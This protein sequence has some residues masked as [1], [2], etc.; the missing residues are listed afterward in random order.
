LT[1]IR[2]HHLLTALPPY[3]DPI[4]PLTERPKALFFD[5]F[6]TCVDWRTTVTQALYTQ[7]HAAL[8]DAT[9]SLATAVRLRATDMT[10][11]HWGIFAQAWRDS[12]KH[13]VQSLAEDPTIPFKTVD[14]H[15]LESLKELL[16]EWKI[17]GL[18]TDEQ[19]EDLSLVWHRLAPWADSAPGIRALN[20]LAQTATLS[21]GNMSLLTDLSAQGQM[22]F[23]HVFSGELFGS[24]K[25]SP[26]VYLG[27]VEKLGLGPGQCAMVAAHLADLKAAKACGLS[28]IYVERP[29]EEDWDVSDIEKAR[30]EG[31]VD[32]WV[33]QGEQG[34]ITV[35]ERLEAVTTSVS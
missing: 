20:R 28:V 33:P 19:V 29:L 6:G 35:A 3:I 21:N 26:K 7:A 32:L 9:N 30:E 4:M 18:W 34:F 8:N 1:L 31:W 14:Q 23:T 11:T 10:I 25:P 27:A 17:E 12:Y 16:L 24:Y 13:F 22:E 5:V 2:S 15:H